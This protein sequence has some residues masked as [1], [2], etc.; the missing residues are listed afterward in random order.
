MS[1]SKTKSALRA[2]R[3]SAGI[4]Y[5]GKLTKTGNSLGFRFEG[6][7]FKSHPEF[8]GEVTA[9]VLAPGRLLITAESVPQDKDDPAM[10]AFLA[11]LAQDISDSPN[12]VVPLSRSLAE[13]VDQ[14]VE[15]VTVS[16]DEDLGSKALL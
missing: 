1:I 15:N 11:F 6:A 8:Q 3:R 12:G 10:T 9:H 2:S 16:E 5:S 14:L 13:R 4:T 7:L